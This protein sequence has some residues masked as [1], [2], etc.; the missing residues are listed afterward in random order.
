M[1]GDFLKLLIKVLTEFF[2]SFIFS[3]VLMYARETL[4]KTSTDQS[5]VLQ[6]YN[7]YL[8]YFL[9]TLAYVFAYRIT[10][11]HFNAA[12]TTLAMLRRHERI[13]WYEGLL[14]IPAQMI[15]MMAGICL[16]W[17]YLRTSSG[18]YLYY[19][20]KTKD[21]WIAEG[22]GMDIAA[23]A[24]FAIVWLTQTD[25][26]TAISQNKLWQAIA[27]AFTYTSAIYWSIDRTGGSLNPTYG[28]LQTFIGMWRT[29]MSIEMQYT[30]LYVVC[31]YVGAFLAWP[32]Y[33]FIFRP[34][35]EVQIGSESNKI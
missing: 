19:N 18:L 11:A 12:I 30:W 15:G 22:V 2:G 17:W 33:E 35:H 16:N 1:A 23:G 3:I 20:R 31:P 4:L 10:G 26:V 28:L 14:Y 5:G 6:T 9:M 32:F 21:Y 7:I 13:K 27:I 34:A 24:I 29:G 25:R 8:L